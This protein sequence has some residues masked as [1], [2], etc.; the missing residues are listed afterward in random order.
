MFPALL[1]LCKAIPPFSYLVTVVVVFLLP[2]LAGACADVV[3]LK[4]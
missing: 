1:S 2:L 3:G 4:I